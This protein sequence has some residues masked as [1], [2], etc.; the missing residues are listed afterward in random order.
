MWGLTPTKSGH[1]MTRVI[2]PPN[3]GRIFDTQKF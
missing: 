2:D 1:A 3:M